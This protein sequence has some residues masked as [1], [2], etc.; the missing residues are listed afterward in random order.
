MSVQRV[1]QLTDGWSE[2][3]RLLSAGVD[4]AR[5]I[6]A[7]AGADQLAARTGLSLGA[8]LRIRSKA[9]DT[10]SRV[11]HVVHALE[12][13]AGHAPFD[14]AVLDEADA[15]PDLSLINVLRRLPGYADLFGNQNYCKCRHCQSIFSPAAYFVDLMSFM[16]KTISKPNFTSKN[17]LDHP[18]YLRNRRGDLWHIPLTCENTDTPEIYL[19]IVNE[20]LAAYLDQMAPLAGDVF[21]ALA[22]ARSSFRQPFNLPFAELML[23]LGHLGVELS[24]VTSLFDETAAAT[25]YSVLRI[26]PEEF[27]TI[28]VPDLTAV[29]ANGMQ[30]DDF[31]NLE[32]DMLVRLNR[33]DRRT[34]SRML[35]LRFVKADL[36]ITTSIESV[37]GDLVGFVERILIGH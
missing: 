10:Q 18:L 24:A 19:T 34:L 32:A 3:D 12:A 14:P 37:S 35:R 7:F 20:V 25:P 29:S 22:D 6:A 11:T 21:E 9:L 36:D 4:T 16:E 17:R 26:S 30:L 1:R 28:A 31:T 2:A 5:R 13:I 23:Y 33:V 8:A 15:G 27:S